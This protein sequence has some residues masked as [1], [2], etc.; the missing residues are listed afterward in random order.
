MLIK[1]SFEKVKRKKTRRDIENFHLKCS[2][3]YFEF[4]LKPICLDQPDI[5]PPDDQQPLEVLLGS[6]CIEKHKLD[7]IFKKLKLC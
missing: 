6:L 4:Q 2:K 7:N 1:K 3:E 5:R